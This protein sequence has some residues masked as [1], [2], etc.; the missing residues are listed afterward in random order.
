M[1]SIGN[2][3]NTE[4]YVSCLAAGNNNNSN[5][6][7]ACVGFSSDIHL[8]ALAGIRV[9]VVCKHMSTSLSYTYSANVSMKFLKNP[10]N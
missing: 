5:L 10:R 2:V 8:S 9:S 4:A 7:V 3:G 1:H 6:L